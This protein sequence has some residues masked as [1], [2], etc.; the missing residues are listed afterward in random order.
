MSI[1]VRI[2]YFAAA[3]ELVGVAEETL[4]VPIDEACTVA[5]MLAALAER[6]PRLAPVIGRMRLA[7]DGDVALPSAQISDG[8][9]IAVLPPV[10]GGSDA[11]PSGLRTEPLSV[12]ELLRALQRPDVGGIALFVGT[13]R[14]HAGETR[15]QRLDYE[16]H[17]SMAER[18]LRSIVDELQK[19][20]PGV[21]VAAV[22]RVGE[23][24]IGELAVV[25]GAAAAHRAE[26]FEVCRAAIE[27][28]KAR[29]PIWKKEWALDGAGS[30]VNLDAP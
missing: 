7:I 24:A 23:L 16:A 29:V 12:D 28:I 15:V 26:A 30:W 10:A 5:D 27:R 22:H 17:P 1:S 21:R 19:E 3:R 9:K 6:H 14:D 11:L 2:E 13:V 18:E 20:Y 4:I 25:V 8:A